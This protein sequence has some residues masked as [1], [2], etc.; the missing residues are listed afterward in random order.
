MGSAGT[1]SSQVAAHVA[2]DCACAGLRHAARATARLYEAA[3]APL[4]LTATQFSILV[5]VHLQ[6]PVPLSRLAE[7]LVLDRT[8]LYRAVKPLERRG[9]LDIRPGRRGRERT[10]ALTDQGRRLLEDALRIWQRVQR[11]FVGAL[12]TRTWPTLH[13]ALA[14]VVPTVQALESGEAPSRSRAAR[15]RPPPS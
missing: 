12:G 9:C 4:N 11:R 8:S 14:H 15:R 1:W 7:R 2:A 10:A 13:S 6:G 3:L 5:A